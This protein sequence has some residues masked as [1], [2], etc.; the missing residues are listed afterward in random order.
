MAEHFEDGDVVSTPDGKGVV[1]GTFD[2]NITW[3]PGSEEGETIEGSPDNPVYIVALVSGGS[4]PYRGEELESAEFDGPDV[5]DEDVQEVAQDVTEASLPSL[6]DKVDDVESL[7]AMHSE[8]A[9]MV[10]VSNVAELSRHR[11]TSEMTYTEL[12]NVPGVDDPK[13]GF[14]D[15]PDS[16]EESEQPA[17]LIALKAWSSM[18]GTWRGC[19][20]DMSEEM[21]PRAS[22]KFCSSFKD[23]IY[24]TEMWRSF[25]D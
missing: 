18:G 4:K 25:Q 1:S 22:R 3:P 10:R 19:F 16:W 8:M 11:G 17:R 15:W 13:V 21:T 24:G 9:G 5:S 23:E 14:S 2:G 20:R 7:E 12:I 6:Y